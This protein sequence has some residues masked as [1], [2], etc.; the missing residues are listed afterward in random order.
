MNIYKIDIANHFG[1][2]AMD[3]LSI[4]HQ[5]WVEASNFYHQNKDTHWSRSPIIGQ[6]LDYYRR[7]EFNFCADSIIFFQAM[8]EVVIN[9]VIKENNHLELKNKKHKIIKQPPFADKWKNAFAHYSIKST[10]LSIY[11]TFYKNYRNPLIH[12][13]TRDIVDN[14]ENIRFPMVYQG[15]YAGWSAFRDLMQALK[16]P[17]DNNSWQLMCDAHQLPIQI[18]PNYYV[19]SQKWVK[20]MYRRHHDGAN[21]T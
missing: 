17:H 20:E 1:H 21:E 3:S 19:D 8:M 5:C 10:D 15:L 6:K 11:T 4:A 7:Q 13:P 16:Q 18:D 12:P 9:Q 2:R 14:A